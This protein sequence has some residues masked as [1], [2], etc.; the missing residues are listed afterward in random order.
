MKLTLE[1][2]GLVL[3]GGAV[4]VC[5]VRWGQ[6]Q[7]GLTL[8]LADGHVGVR[9]ERMEFL[10]KI[11]GNQVGEVDLV[12]G[13]VQDREENFLKTEK[14]NEFCWTVLKFKSKKVLTTRRTVTE[15]RLFAFRF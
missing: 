5:N 15:R 12:E 6:G 3:A 14:V 9:E 7:Q 13:V 10:H 8:D 4:T 11:L 2:V 1:D